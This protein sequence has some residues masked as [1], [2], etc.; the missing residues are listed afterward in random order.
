MTNYRFGTVFA[1]IVISVVVCL[2]AV[3]SA[4]VRE[5]GQWFE[6]PA[7]VAA[8]KIRGG[9]LAQI[10]GNLNGLPHEMKYINAP[11]DVKTYTPALPNGA[12]TDDDTD[13]EWVYICA[14][15]KNDELFIPPA[16]ISALWKKHINHH[17]WCSNRYA[18]SLMD[19]GIDPP[20]TGRM[21]INP[22]AEFNISGQFLC[23][24]FGLVAPAMP[25]TAAR[26]GL[27]YIHTGIEGEP[28][29][30]TQMFTAMIATAFAVDDID[31]ILD[32]GLQMLDA[33]STVGP[34]VRD[35]RRWHGENPKDWRRTRKLVKQKYSKYNGAM[36]D[37]NG[38]ELNTASTVA[39]LL[40]GEGDFVETLRIAFN[41]GWDADNNAATA[42]TIVGVI[43]GHK[44]M[45][46]QG[47][48][49]KDVY[50]NTT[51]DQMP[52][53]ET[54]TRFGDRLITVAQ[55]AIR[56][57]GGEVITADGTTT[58][59]IRMQRPQC[60]ELLGDPKTK[61]QALRQDMYQQLAADLQNTDDKLSPARAAYMAICLDLAGIFK[62]R[63]P[64]PWSRALDA[65][66]EQADMLK[67]LYDSPTPAA[68]TLQS[69]IDAA[70]LKRPE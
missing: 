65:L 24:S 43:R 7:T 30:T 56:Q 14:M 26:L 2:S 67:V 1:G 38:Y 22:W 8:D 23:E 16:Q 32:A 3:S 37:R 49:I 19:L 57:N 54:I 39:A 11:G 13:I 29:Q 36:R 55:R 40:Y 64:Q 45:Q 25:Q 35:V 9:L 53:D 42:A 12:R 27:H 15:E 46:Q 20:M 34:I 70:G 21:A 60:V 4:A 61:F 33:Q 10:L 52:N 17:I 69:R 18:R 62:Q 68:E 5:Q 31:T 50:R 6:L 48:N 66:R 58:W 44:W 47:W 41:F 51:R 28:A 59:R 63:Y